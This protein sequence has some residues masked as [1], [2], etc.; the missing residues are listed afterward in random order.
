MHLSRSCE[1]ALLAVWHLARNSGSEYVLIRQIAEEN[2]ISFYFLSKVLHTLTQK[3]ILVSHRGPRGGVALARPAEEIMIIEIVEA[4]DGLT[5]RQRC[6]TGLPRCDDENPCPLHE[7]WKKIREEIDRMLS[8]K[9]VAQFMTER[10]GPGNP[11][12]KERSP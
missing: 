7:E 12:S 3:G 11:R 10:T 2:G 1:Y 9:S 5:F 6:I 8:A 4:I